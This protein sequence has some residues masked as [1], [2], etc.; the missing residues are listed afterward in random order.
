MK[1]DKCVASKLTVK[2]MDKIAKEAI[3]RMPEWIKNLVIKAEV[4]EDKK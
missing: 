2:E 3:E 4:K 1:L